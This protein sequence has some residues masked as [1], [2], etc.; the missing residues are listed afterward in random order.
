MSFRVSMIRMLG[1]GLVLALASSTSRA[2]VL[3]QTFSLPLTQTNWDP[4]TGAFSGANPFV[5]QQFDGAAHPLNGG[6][7]TLQSVT[8]TMDYEFDNT[9]RATHANAS[10]ITVTAHGDLSLSV[11][12]VTTL[13]G[14]FDNSGSHTASASDTFPE[15]VT[16][17]QKTFTGTKTATYTDSANL[18]NF[19]GTGTISAP[20]VA[21]ATSSFSTSSGNGTGGSR[22]LAAVH[23]TVSYTYV[24]E[25]GSFVL[26][27]LGGL[28]LFV[29]QRRRSRLASNQVSPL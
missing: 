7:S 10:T 8:L 22:T 15:V 12:N 11:P 1:V 16:I 17:N 21:T 28:G 14:S 18:A 2:D 13:T 25:P 27:G 9:L 23:L 26:M 4:T 3:T 6:P 29:V 5:I 19:T 20:A 24:P